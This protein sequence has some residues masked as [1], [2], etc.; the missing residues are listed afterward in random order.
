M[1]LIEDAL[2]FVRLIYFVSANLMETKNP[3]DDESPDPGYHSR[4]RKTSYHSRRGSRS[5][6][7]YI[8]TPRR[9]TL[10]DL[11]NPPRRGSKHTDYE[12]PSRRESK[13]LETGH[14]SRRGSKYPDSDHPPSSRRG[15]KYVDTGRRN[16]RKISRN[17]DDPL[18]L[19]TKREGSPKTGRCDS[20]IH[21]DENGFV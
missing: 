9:H 12:Y 1:I 14:H 13:V 6:E 8:Q 20:V 17:E 10:G 21:E 5:Y 15:S 19:P 4:S 2:F 7:G 16:S 3:S 11:Y 18:N